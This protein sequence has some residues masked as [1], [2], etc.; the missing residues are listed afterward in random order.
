MRTV[1]ERADRLG[2]GPTR[3]HL[4]HARQRID[5]GPAHGTGCQVPL[6]CRALGSLEIPVQVIDDRFVAIVRVSAECFIRHGICDDWRV[7]PSF[8]SSRRRT[9]RP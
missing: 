4:P 7:A 5:F 2:G 8:S 9:V 1:F 6:E 3:E